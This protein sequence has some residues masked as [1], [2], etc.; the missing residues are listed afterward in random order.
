MTGSSAAYTLIPI[1]TEGESVAVIDDFSTSTEHLA[2]VARSAV[3][4]P[5]NNH[6]PGHRAPAPPSYLG[7]R[8][9]V[10]KAVLIDAFGMTNGADLIECNFSFVTTPP[11]QLTP[12]Q[13]LP[14]FDGMDPNRLAL[15]H[16]L[17]RPEEGGT[18]FYRHRQTG[19]ERITADRLSR[20]NAALQEESRR[21]RASTAA[22]FFGSNEAFE[23]IRTIEARWNRMIIYRGLLLHSGDVPARTQW[24]T[25]QQTARLTINTFLAARTVG[26]PGRAD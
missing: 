25:D 1:G 23:C 26:S 14:H 15:L 2:V 19:F 17:C 7:E 24:P 6:Y 13:R 21:L 22:Y 20:Y 9:D 12:I 4:E 11:E 16:Y 3:L 8:A 18:S 5:G 10:L